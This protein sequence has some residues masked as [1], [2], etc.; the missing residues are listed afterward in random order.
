MAKGEHR[1][2]ARLA[3]A[4]A[5]YQMELTGKGIAEVLAEFETYWIGLEIDDEVYKPAE[6]AFFR[7][8]LTGVLADQV[9]LDRL[10]DERLQKGWPL[11]RIEALMRAILRAGAYEL[12][13]RRD[14]PAR[15]AIVEYVDV[16]GA[17][18]ARE[19]AGMING[20]LDAIARDVRAEEFA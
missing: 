3:A 9:A 16:A 6:R 19:E 18:F 4:Q 15:A 5:L 14:V 13:K 7:D 12:K 10:I 20:V 17:F 1:A 8:L 2:T 11:T